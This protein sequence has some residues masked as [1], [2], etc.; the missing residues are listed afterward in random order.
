[1][2][3][4]QTLILLS[5]FIFVSM[6]CQENSRSLEEVKIN[7]GIVSGELS[8]DQQVVAFKGIP[9]AAPPVGNLRWKAPQPTTPWE[10]VLACDQFSASAMQPKPEPFFMWT[11]EFIAPA[12]P[13]SED[14]LY[15]NVWTSA[16][17]K[18]EKQP[19]M[20]FI[21]IFKT[22]SFGGGHV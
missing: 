19:V 2:N 11:S 14:C 16:K 12:E 17:N 7:D 18:D 20:V 4:K 9:F 6:S 22:T 1:M 21:I 8:D 15:L 5:V 13:L 3:I 10:G